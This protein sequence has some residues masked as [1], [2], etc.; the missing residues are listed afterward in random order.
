MSRPLPVVFTGTTP[1]IRSAVRRLVDRVDADRDP[2]AQL[3]TATAVQ[4]AAG[5]VREDL[6]RICIDQGESYA[7]VGRAAGVT[8]EAARK[9]WPRK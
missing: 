1:Q 7:D 3:A 8:R 9:R 5:Q 4:A 2:L 6:A